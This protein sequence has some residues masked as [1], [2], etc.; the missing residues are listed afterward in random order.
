LPAK[1]PS[2]GLVILKGNIFDAGEKEVI[3]GPILGLSRDIRPEDAKAGFVGMGSLNMDDV[4]DARFLYVCPR[5]KT[6]LLPPININQ[7]N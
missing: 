6:D 7:N 4:P 5:C 3:Y 1:C 2:C